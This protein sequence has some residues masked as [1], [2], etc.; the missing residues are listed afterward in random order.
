MKSG[1]T[2][3]LLTPGF[4]KDEADTS[5]IPLLQEFVRELKTQCKDWNIYIIALQYPPVNENYLWNGIPVFSIGGNDSKLS[6]LSVWRKAWKHLKKIHRDEKIDCL[7]SFWLSETTFLAQRFAHRFSIPHIATALGQDVKSSNRYLRFLNFNK[8]TTVTI[9][10]WQQKFLSARK[11][12]SKCIPIGVNP[13]SFPGDNRDRS[14]D[15]L[16]AGS[17]SKLK[18]YELFISVI[19]DV[20]K[21]FP[22]IRA[23]L[24][25]DG[26]ERTRLQE[27]AQNSGLENNLHFSGQIKREETLKYMEQTK[28]FLHTSAFEG[29]G[30]VLLEALGS[31]CRVISAN[32]GIAPQ[33]EK[34]SVC[35]NKE[36]MANA[37]SR[38]LTGHFIPDRSFPFT[39]QQTIARYLH[40]YS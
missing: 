24:I 4:A 27:L 33:I 2:I 11:I 31:G 25:G 5:C 26:P 7:H 9:S 28:I 29:E 37:V 32:V 38:V 19:A 10:E 23:V 3:V 18:N 8:I 12:E 16:G 20:K 35:A 30:F 6:R 1:K 15:V 13:G 21:L 17:L 34:I 22:E 14:I 39:I 40:L 36:E